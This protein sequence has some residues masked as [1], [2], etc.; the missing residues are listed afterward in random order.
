MTPRLNG[1]DA[2]MDSLAFSA[3]HISMANDHNNIIKRHYQDLLSMMYHTINERHDLA[4]ASDEALAKFEYIPLL[5]R[6][7][8]A[9]GAREKRETKRKIRSRLEHVLNKQLVS[10]RTWAAFDACS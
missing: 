8:A 3:S 1:S 10:T 6:F 9:C 5:S 2:T 7:E 4:S